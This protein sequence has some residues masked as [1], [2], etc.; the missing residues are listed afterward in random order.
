MRRF[1]WHFSPSPMTVSAS[2]L[3]NS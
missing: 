1:H 3:V 2:K